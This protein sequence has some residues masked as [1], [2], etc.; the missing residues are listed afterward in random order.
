MLI[1][2]KKAGRAL[3]AEGLD[4][5][6]VCGEV[7]FLLP[8]IWFYQVIFI[9]PNTSSLRNSDFWVTSGSGHFTYIGVACSKYDTYSNINNLFG[10]ALHRNTS[11]S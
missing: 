4:R 1:F 2:A 7:C 9:S 3:S 10:S 6:I 5:A 11:T 8:L